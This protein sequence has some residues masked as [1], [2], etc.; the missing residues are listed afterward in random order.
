MRRRAPQKPFTILRPKPG[1]CQVCAVDHPSEDPHNKESLY[2]QCTFHAKHN[3]WPTWKDA[4]EH[5]SEG[6]KEEWARALTDRGVEL[7]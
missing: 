5:C 6:T 4:M 3:R 7:G 1:V 2:Y